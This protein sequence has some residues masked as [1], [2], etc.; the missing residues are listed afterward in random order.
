MKVAA[1]YDVHG[2]LDALD[3]VL[4]EVEREDVDLIVLGGD[5]IQGPQPLETLERLRALGDRALWIRGNTDRLIAEDRDLESVHAKVSSMLGPA[6]VA[7]LLGLPLDQRLHLDGL[8]RVVFCHGT[9][10]SDEA[11]LESDDRLA[12]L[13]ADVV[14][15]GHTH[16]QEDR[17]IGRVR[18]VNA[19]SV[20]LPRDRLS[21]AWALLGPEVELRRTPL[22][23]GA[24]VEALRRG[25]RGEAEHWIA[26]LE[27]LARA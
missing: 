2:M 8:G 23:I 10:W 9:P 16:V 17:R 22:D 11:V 15:C 4:E 1:L 19:G 27:G 26:H 24:A 12:D 3:A 21:S 6:N 14:V 7:F 18:W 5:C 13:D 20:G 25:G